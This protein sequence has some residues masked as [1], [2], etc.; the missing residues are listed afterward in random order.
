MKKEYKESNK[1]LE[2]KKAPEVRTRRVPT[3]KI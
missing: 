3:R 1:M 2:E